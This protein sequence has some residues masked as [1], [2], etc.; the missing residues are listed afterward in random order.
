[1]PNTS[2][3]P[4]SQ[5][6]NK[7]LPSTLQVAE[8]SVLIPD[9]Q[10]EALESDLFH[11]LSQLRRGSVVSPRSE[12]V[13]M[14]RLKKEMRM[15]REEHEEQ[16]VNGHEILYLSPNGDVEKHISASYRDEDIISTE[17][18]ET[19]T[20]NFYA[21]MRVPGNPPGLSSASRPFLFEG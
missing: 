17:P 12:H 5:A 19:R 2:V 15:L 4:V 16:P 1:L 11:D 8:P 14:D 9:H 10:I 7:E 3:D 6:S 18:A 21:P 13:N 20:P